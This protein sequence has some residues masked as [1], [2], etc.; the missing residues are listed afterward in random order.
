MEQSFSSSSKLRGNYEEN[1][2]AHY[3]S[4]LVQYSFYQ[5]HQN[6]FKIQGYIRA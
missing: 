1:N 6:H 5:E 2:L 3:N 4:G